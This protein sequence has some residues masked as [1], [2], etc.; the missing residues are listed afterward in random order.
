LV[1]DNAA[2]SS[3]R[4]VE[5]EFF[6]FIAAGV[7]YRPYELASKT[8]L[9]IVVEPGETLG[10]KIYDMTYVPPTNEPENL[11]FSVNIREVQTT[12]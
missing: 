3:S 4:I 12:S 8:G 6:E 11:F 10:L 5:S 2:D 1:V 7:G 9:S